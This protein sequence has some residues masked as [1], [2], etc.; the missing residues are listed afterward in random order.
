MSISG[1]QPINIGQPN[2]PANSDSLYCAFNTVQNNFT[3][4][5]SAASPITTLNAGTGIVISNSNPNTYTICNTGVTCLVPG[6]GITLSANTGCITINST[7]GGNGGSGTV[8]SVGANSTS[9]CV[10]NSPVTSSGN[11]GIELRAVPNVSGC[12]VNPNVTVDCYGRVTAVSNGS[13]SGTVTSVAIASGN[14]IAVSGGPITTTGTL[15]VCNTGV[16]SIVAGTGIVIDQA[17]GAVTICST[18]G[19]GG[20]SGTVTRVGVCSNS[21]TVTGSPITT[22]G[23]IYVE[24][25]AYLN[26]NS[27]CVGAL[28]SNVLNVNIS[29]A[30]ANTGVII[31]SAN[32]NSCGITFRQSRGT[33]GSP[34]CSIAG[35]A[36]MNL[37]T[38]A[39]TAYGN[40]QCSGGIKITVAG[41][42]SSPSLPSANSFVESCV[43]LYSTGIPVGNTSMQ[44]PF[45]LTNSGN[46]CT[47]GRIQTQ[48]INSACAAPPAFLSIRARGTDTSNLA[49]LCVGD[50]IAR[51]AAYGYTGNGITTWLP[52]ANMA[53]AG[54]TEFVV[55]ALPSGNGR[56]IPSDFIISTINANNG[57]NELT[58][59]STG[60]LVM[61][62]T[63]LGGAVSVSGNVTAN[64]VAATLTTAL[65]PNITCVGTLANLSVTGTANIGN[66]TTSGIISA[67]GNVRGANINTAGIVSATGNISA[68]GNVIG[69]NLTTAGVV[70]A[71]GN[72]SGGNLTTVGSIS[73]TGN[74]TV[75][76]FQTTLTATANTTATLVAT[77]P[78][79][80]NG[81][82]YKMMLTQ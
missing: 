26:A 44:Y 49:I 43:T 17:V 7:G 16:T 59:T 63:Y 51:T 35:D 32:A 65:Q 52:G 64:L 57:C 27:I 75:G 50:S 38:R 21:L 11:I 60:N 25:P 39:Y 36:M 19:G 81:V 40:Y 55:A 23:N 53:R 29:N 15:C 71:T 10:T 72:I 4:L 48:L 68:T 8:T 37:Q 46:I 76:G 12:Y 56:Q 28:T 41:N 82:A 79:V 2:N 14:G 30:A 45:V 34:C 78:I 13:S 42:T 77:I 62:G 61:T 31:S 1:Q 5:F 67:T 20:G 74:I 80:V 73:A 6:T 33:I 9:L 3:C 24:L 66:I 18:G 69:G 54:W 47:P 70:A 22:S 58:Y